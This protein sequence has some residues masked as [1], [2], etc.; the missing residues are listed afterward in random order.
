MGMGPRDGADFEA[1]YRGAHPRLIAALVAATGSLDVAGDA[2]DEAFL[3]ALERWNRV[4]QMAS[5]EGWTYKVA[6]NAAR[7]KFRRQRRERVLLHRARPATAIPGP[8]GELWQIV[9]GLP[10]RQRQAVVLRHVGQLTE[11][12]VGE[13]MGITR[14]TVSSTL[15]S[16]YAA[17]REVVDRSDGSPEFD[18]A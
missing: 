15:R 1:W 12:E 14:G 9:A 17:I 16:A 3:R 4:R 7:R 6:L 5:P 13:V 2:A 10:E 8:A 11:A 18:R